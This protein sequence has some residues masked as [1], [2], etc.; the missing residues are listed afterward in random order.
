MVIVVGDVE[1]YYLTPFGIVAVVFHIRQL[2]TA[3]FLAVVC[4]DGAL[5][6]IPQLSFLDG[7]AVSNGEPHNVTLCPSVGIEAAGT[8]EYIHHVV[9]AVLHSVF[10]PLVL[11]LVVD[12]VLTEVRISAAVC[13]PYLVNGVALSLA[14][15]L[16]EIQRFHV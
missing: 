7:V 16:T 9:S 6:A 3:V 11:S 12:A 10:V 1:T 15:S 13:V 14:C 2:Q 5:A 8:E 4:L